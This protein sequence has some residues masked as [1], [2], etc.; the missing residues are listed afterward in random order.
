MSV[1]L[2]FLTL[3][4]LMLMSF[5]PRCQYEETHLLQPHDMRLASTRVCHTIFPAGHSASAERPI[6]T[7]VLSI[8]PIRHALNNKRHESLPMLRWLFTTHLHYMI[9]DAKGSL[10]HRLCMPLLATSNKTHDLAAGVWT[11]PRIRS[12]RKRLRGLKEGEPYLV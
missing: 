2:C 7:T 8:C 5:V 11:M 1:G 4:K 3:F 6:I 10:L 12:T 9:V